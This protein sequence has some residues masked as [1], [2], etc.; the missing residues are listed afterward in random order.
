MN[1]L[2]VGMGAERSGSP[3]L[4]L[5]LGA[6]SALAADGAALY[7]ANCASCHGADG[8]ADTPV[9]NAMN[10]A[11]LVGEAH[12]AAAV[13]EHVRSSEKHKAVSGA[14]SD[15]ELQAIGAAVAKMSGG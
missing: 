7:S 14:L 13:E 12:S 2:L 5:A 3:I 10:V 6:S 4:M 11:S 9:G 1:A 15:E 8:T